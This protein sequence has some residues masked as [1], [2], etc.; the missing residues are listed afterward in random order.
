MEILA[1]AAVIGDAAH[2]ET[3]LDLLLQHRV[4]TDGKMS[5]AK[6]AWQNVLILSC[7][8]GQYFG[9]PAS[10]GQRCQSTV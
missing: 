8:S 5:K 9:S 6:R 2:P 4:D 7:I 1:N 3:T 10:P